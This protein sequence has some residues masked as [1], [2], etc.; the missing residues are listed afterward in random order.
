MSGE[1]LRAEREEPRNVHDRYAVSL[2]KEDVGDCRAHPQE[3]LKT[4][5][6]ARKKSWAR[7]EVVGDHN[8]N[9]YT[10]FTNATA[11][12]N[13]SCK[14]HT[15]VGVKSCFRGLGVAL[16]GCLLKGFTEV[17]HSV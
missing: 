5:Y 15:F 14:R 2:I 6:S 11:K 7:L 12:N 9:N 3:D 4:R 1:V 13:S 10:L 17:V 16:F 8:D